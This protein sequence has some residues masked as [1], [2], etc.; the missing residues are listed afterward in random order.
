MLLSNNKKFSEGDVITIKLSSGE[1]VL[2][3]LV[4]EDIT[5]ITLSKPLMIAMTQKGPAMAPILMTVNPEKNLSFSKSQITIIDESDKEIAD[6]Y[7]YQTTGIQP[8]SAGS[9]VTR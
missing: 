5:T 7:T 2:G 3:K 1:E 8:V 9:I 4:S 6:Q